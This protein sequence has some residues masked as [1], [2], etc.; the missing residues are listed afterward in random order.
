M[1]VRLLI[2]SPVEHGMNQGCV[3]A[4]TLCTLFLTAVLDVTNH[5]VKESAEQ[6]ALMA[7]FLTYDISKQRQRFV[8]CAHKTLSILIGLVSLS[9]CDL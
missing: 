9:I 3:L 2:R 8:R 1:T 7:G 4:P 5:D 6:H